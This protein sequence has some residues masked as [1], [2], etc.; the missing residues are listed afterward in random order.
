[1]EGEVENLFF[2]VYIYFF[3]FGMINK[4][5]YRVDGSVWNDV[6]D[7][8]NNGQ[9][10]YEYKFVFYEK[11]EDSDFCCEVIF[12]FLYW[13]KESGELYIYGIYVCKNLGFFNVQ[14]N[15]VYD[16]DFI[17][18]CLFWVYLVLVEIVNMESDNVN[19]ER[20]INLVRNRVYKFEIGLYI[21]KVFDFLINE[22]VILYEKDKEFVQEGQCWWDLC[23]MK[24]VKDGI[25]LVFCKE[26][27]IEGK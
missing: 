19:V 22:L 7:I 12:M 8:Q 17:F 25:L 5:S 24:N 14:G 3:V 13:K 23:C 18:Y 6:F 27:D 20:Y 26:G 11:F 10:Q 4:D 1:M 21:Y 16:G 9:Q 2:C 15:R